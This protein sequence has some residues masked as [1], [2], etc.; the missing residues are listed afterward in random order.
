MEV[1]Q[2]R[3]ALEVL[4]EIR[5]NRQI[6]GEWAMAQAVARWQSQEH[7]EALRHFGFAVRDQPEWENSNWVRA[8]Y[9]PRVAESIAQMQAEHE[10]QR[11]R[12]AASR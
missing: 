6:P 5:S 1:R 8:L 2:Y 7:E 10:R 12:A 9:S 4:N 11:A 3:D